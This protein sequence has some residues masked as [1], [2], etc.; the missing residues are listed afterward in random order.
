MASLATAYDFRQQ[1]LQWLEISK[2]RDCSR[3]GLT[4]KAT[5]GQQHGLERN[6]KN[7]FQNILP[8]YCADCAFGFMV[9]EPV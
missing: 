3:G 5:P 1:R 7:F 6:K 2:C 8:L 4:A 9:T